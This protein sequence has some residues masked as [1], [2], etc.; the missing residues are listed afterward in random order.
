MSKRNSTQPIFTRL[1]DR[2]AVL[3]VKRPHTIVTCT[4]L[5]ALAGYIAAGLLWFGYESPVSQLPRNHRERLAWEETSRATQFNSEIFLRVRASDST[6]DNQLEKVVDLLTQKLS[7]SKEHFCD[8]LSY[9][10]SND[11]TLPINTIT[12]LIGIPVVVIVIVRN[13]KVF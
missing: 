3:C 2:W 8:I 9:S 5:F 6:T 1:F 11:M 10:V 7:A 4:V 13:K 12:A